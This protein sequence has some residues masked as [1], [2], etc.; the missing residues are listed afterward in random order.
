M[1]S[2]KTESKQSEITCKQSEPA[3]TISEI[4]KR[5]EFVRAWC[6]EQCPKNSFKRFYIVKGLVVLEKKLRFRKNFDE[7][8][9]A[10]KRVML[11]FDDLTSQFKWSLF[12]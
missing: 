5:R 6:Y 1:Q 9:N 12:G 3:R 7:N 10:V 4:Q 8:F 2:R 11:L